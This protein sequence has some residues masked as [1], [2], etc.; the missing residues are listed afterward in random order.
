MFFIYFIISLSIFYLFGFILFLKSNLI[1]HY[2]SFFPFY[3]RIDFIP[4][5]FLFVSSIVLIGLLFSSFLFFLRLNSPRWRVYKG[6]KLI[7]F[8]RKNK[9]KFGQTISYLRKIDPFVFEELLLSLFY[10]RGFKIRRNKRYTG[11]GGI[12][13][14]VFFGSQKYLIQ[15]KRYSK[16][17][18]KK[19]VLEFNEL[20]LKNEAKGFFI[21]T[22]K[23]GLKAKE[24]ATD[25]VCF[26]SGE[27][28]YDFILK[29]D[30]CFFDIKYKPIRKIKDK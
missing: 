2:Q 8:F 28:L 27:Q 26:V 13:G 3:N 11:D 22:G 25:I 30:V 20:C 5:I 1:D 29:K 12:D 16:Y 6:N 15:A 7:F 18:N 21:H 9:F 4:T 17:I 19:H 10:E 23:T 24:V 14:I